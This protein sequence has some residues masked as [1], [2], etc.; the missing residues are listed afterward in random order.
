MQKAGDIAAACLVITK[1]YETKIIKKTI[2]N[3]KIDKTMIT[4]NPA[5]LGILLK[6]YNF[7]F[8]FYP[9]GGIHRALA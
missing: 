2:L 3:A 1:N 4:A 6:F 5:A 7:R 9:L 8:I